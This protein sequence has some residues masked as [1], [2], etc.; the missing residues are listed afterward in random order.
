MLQMPAFIVN[1]ALQGDVD[2]TLTALGRFGINAVMGLG[3][4]DEDDEGDGKKNRGVTPKSLANLLVNSIDKRD[5]AEKAGQLAADSEK[6]LKEQQELADQE[7]PKTKT[8][9]PPVTDGP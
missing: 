9:E 1:H 7:N 5:P 6:K 4:G 2:K 3:D 8:Q